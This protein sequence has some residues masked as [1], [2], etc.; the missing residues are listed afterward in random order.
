MELTLGNTSYFLF[1]VHDRNTGAKSD[2][3]SL[4]TAAIT[5]DAGS[6]LGYAPTVTKISTGLYRIPVAHSSANGFAVDT[7][8]NVRAVAVQDG[9]TARLP[10]ARFR[11]RA[12]A[13]RGITLGDSISIEFA[14]TNIA[15]QAAQ[16]AAST[17]AIAIYEDA[18]GSAM[19]YTP[20]PANKATGV[21]IV[22]IAATAANGFAANKSYNIVASGTVAGVAGHEVISTFVIRPASS[23]TVIEE[24]LYSRLTNDAGVF[25]LVGL[26]VYPQVIPQDAAY[27]A[28]AYE[29]LTGEH[30]RSLTGSSQAANPRYELTCWG[31]T[32]NSAKSVSEAVRGCLDGYVGTV[33]GVKIMKCILEDDSDNLEQT[34]GAD[35]QTRYGVTM[36]F[37]IWHE[38]SDP[39]L[40]A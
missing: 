31:A 15:T 3:D 9:Q 28:I 27:P 14:T 12:N 10:I 19:G 1:T 18:G 6:A 8:Y 30:I 26:R 24:A 35:R 16:D 20:T 4:P 13:W 5:P 37:N 17:P 38:E 21:Y 23:A 33:G 11:L 22:T 36:V 2:A 34:A 32:R 25:A 39:P 40:S 7:W 29:R